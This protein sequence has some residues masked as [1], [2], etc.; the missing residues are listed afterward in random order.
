MSSVDAADSGLVSDD[1]RRN[2]NGAMRGQ[3]PHYYRQSSSNRLH[4]IYRRST[5]ASA[6]RS[7][8]HTAAGIVDLESCELTGID[9][10]LND[11]DLREHAGSGNGSI[12]DM[13]QEH[14]DNYVAASNAHENGP[15]NSMTS[16][17]NALRRFFGRVMIPS[18][19]SSGRIR[20]NEHQDQN[21][22]ANNNAGHATSH[23]SSH[24]ESAHGAT[25]NAPPAA[26]PNANI[27]ANTN[28]GNIRR[29]RRGTATAK[30]DGN[31]SSSTSN[32]LRSARRHILK[33]AGVSESSL[34]ARSVAILRW[35][36]LIVWIAS[37]CVISFVF[38]QRYT[39]QTEYDDFEFQYNTHAQKVLSTFNAA[40]GSKLGAINSMA[41]TITMYARY[42]NETFPCVTVPDFVMAAGNTRVLADAPVIHWLPLVTDDKRDEWEEYAY[43]NRFQ[44]N[45]AHD[46]DAYLR[47]LQD[48]ELGYSGEAEGVAELSKFSGYDD[49][50]NIKYDNTPFE[51]VTV[52]DNVVQ[53]GTRYH[54]R[55]WALNNNSQIKEEGIGPFLPLWQRSP[56]N[57]AMQFTV[58]IDFATS[59]GLKGIFPY[60]LNQEKRGV[61][62]NHADIP[63]PNVETLLNDNILKS[64]FRHNGQPYAGDPETKVAYPVFDGFE[65]AKANFVGVLSTTLYWRSY[66][67]DILP[68]DAKGIICVLENDFNQT[69]AYRIDGANATF[70]GEGDPLDRYGSDFIFRDMVVTSSNNNNGPDANVRPIVE[71]RSY[72]TLPIDTGYNSYTIR[73]YPTQDTLNV[74][75]TNRPLIYTS[76]VAS[77]FVLAAVV[78]LAYGENGNFIGVL[79]S[80]LYW[81]SYFI[82]IL[83]PD[84]KGII[85]VLENDF[86]QTFAYRIDGA[87]ATFLGEGDPLDRY[88]SDF[89]FRDMAVTSFNNVN[90]NGPDA[91]ARSTVETRSYTTLPIDTGYN[92]YTIRIYPTQDT[93]NVHRTNQPLIY[94]SLVA[95]IFVLAAVVF[96]AY[97]FCVQ[98]RQQLMASKAI[99]NAQ[100]AAV[101]ERDLNEYIAH[102]V[103]NP[104][105]AA[106]SACS[107][108]S[109]AVNETQPLADDQS[110]Q[111]VREDVQI[112]NSS[113]SFVNELLRNLLD[114]HRA[115][116]R[117]IKIRMRQTDLFEEVLKPVA[118][119]LYRRDDNYQ[120]I[121]ECCPRHLH[122]DTDVL[123]L[124][125]V[126]L[127]LGRNASKFVKS[128]FLRLRAEVDGGDECECEYEYENGA[129]RGLGSGNRDE[130]GA[131]N[132]DKIATSQHS[133]HNRGDGRGIKS[134]T[135][136][137]R[138][139]G[140]YRQRSVRLYV[141][142][143]GPGI[144]RENRKHLF[145]KFQQSLDVTT[146]GVGI[147]LCLCKNL[148][149][150]M[151]GELIV[152]CCPRH[153]RVDADVLRLKQV[154]LNL[155]RNASKF[156]KSGFLRLRAEVNGGD[157]CECEYEYEYEN[158][159]ELAIGSCHRDEEGGCNNDEIATS[160]HSGHNRG[161]GRSIKSNTQ[162]KR[163]DGRYRQ[164]SVRLYVE[165]SGPGISEE[166]RK[167]LFSKFQQ[168]LDVTT[169]GVGIGLCL[170]KNLLDIM[171][172]D[173][174][175]DESFDSGIPGQPGTR[176]VIDLKTL[177]YLPPPIETVVENDSSNKTDTDG[178][179][180]IDSNN[181]NINNADGG[182]MTRIMK[183]REAG[184]KMRSRDRREVPNNE[185][186]ESQMD[187]ET[188]GERH[189]IVLTSPMTSKV[190]S[191]RVD[192][193]SVSATTNADITLLDIT[194]PTDDILVHDPTKASL[195]A[196][197]LVSSAM[198][199]LP[200]QP[201]TMDSKEGTFD[202][203]EQA[204]TQA[205][206]KP[207]H[208]ETPSPA[209]LFAVLAP[210]LE[211]PKQAHQ[212]QPAPLPAAGAVS[213][214][215]SSASNAPQTGA[216]APD[217]PPLS[218]LFVDDDKV[219]R[220]LFNRCIKRAIPGLTVQEAPDGET[221]LDM[222]N[223][224]AAAADADDDGKN[225]DS[226]PFDLI[227]MD[228]YMSTTEKKLLGTETVMELRKRGVRSKICGLSANDVEREFME[229]GANAFICKPLSCNKEE[230]KREV[231]RILSLE[232]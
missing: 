64:Q 135:Q 93:L 190:L 78:F 94:T 169:Q 47:T 60:M 132:S 109:S 186:A 189:S 225:D 111:L 13:E 192:N 43:D 150:I 179:G 203:Q 81:R 35:T 107:F 193:G 39:K 168:S 77:I 53:D 10:A 106:L 136:R 148:L 87:N 229:A 114:L 113:L 73:I 84:A 95:S 1:D 102:E 23:A 207:H 55:I 26:E 22:T 224:A 28:A 174:W 52:T 188:N 210:P 30:D 25:Q 92:S 97:D 119:I 152:E 208:A 51:N 57:K 7:D 131:R 221:A 141:E 3:V 181:N 212:Q 213:A 122:V 115:T 149:D 127:N 2:S 173:I 41:T 91:N 199:V 215:E 200:S 176:F 112:I 201:E 34:E 101:A 155:G 209:P 62:L 164:R 50:D 118:S 120:L 12:S 86:N 100:K 68:P 154:L 24:P 116:D 178:N 157:D 19:Q 98:K 48:V 59:K 170:C 161:D 228:Q 223:A 29:R 8:M 45:R 49:A 160:Q 103:R 206:G 194:E 31:D 108:V 172:G 144:P 5:S 89:I 46:Q 230:L 182:G 205:D 163:N 231:E 79:S 196:S 171:G 184:D 76:L 185:P 33:A 133:G 11:D 61:L 121:V 85:C 38:V 75:Q 126:L 32:S 195:G 191:D 217:R 159:V 219:L 80:S 204:N 177:P 40:I 4:R 123:R 198:D 218:V 146:Q 37:A 125:Q 17:S 18:R 117:K 227:F 147:G 21:G 110:K 138:N 27:N 83:P 216:T 14:N 183:V 151:G 104:L 134:S 36:V 222:V 180:G 145:S 54:P 96:L 20:R 58:N 74:H 90:N 142:D 65:S 137:K 69:F 128:G 99:E 105:S 42:A 15:R 153:L 16:P 88:S 165:D 9:L 71:T 72:T 214:V 82:D 143:S 140:R 158:G 211:Q 162:R 67:I 232:D 187:T 139:D 56:V 63:N 66:F 167:H 129:G 166:N 220:K 226:K 124:K 175:L 70:L 197:L 6:R 130:G 202:P 156:V 44:V